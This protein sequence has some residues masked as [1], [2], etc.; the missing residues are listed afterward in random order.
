MLLL[1]KLCITFNVKGLIWGMHPQC[2]Q[3]HLHPLSLPQ[4][5]IKLYLLPYY[6]ALSSFCS[7][8]VVSGNP[9]FGLMKALHILQL[10][11]RFLWTGGILDDYGEGVGQPRCSL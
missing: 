1:F 2:T 8:H 10:S 4:K 9:E 6:I 5:R 3:V 11:V 7:R